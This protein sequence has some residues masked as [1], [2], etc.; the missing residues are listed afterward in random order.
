MSCMHARDAGVSCDNNSLI[1]QLLREALALFE[2]DRPT[3]RRRVLHAC[4]LVTSQTP[5]G[6]H[7]PGKLAPWQL[8]RTEKHIRE[9][10]GS[11]LRID[12]VAAAV[13]LSPNHF[14][15]AFKATVGVSYTS[16]L[17]QARIQQA[18]R[19]LLTT[20]TPIC[21]IALICG[22][23]DQSHLTRLFTRQVGLPPRAWR[24]YVLGNEP[25]AFTGDTSERSLV[26]PSADL[27]LPIVD[28]V[29]NRKTSEF[30]ARDARRVA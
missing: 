3:A 11:K 17:I 5:S 29:P 1:S 7:L 10:L 14:S 22:L 15:R 6:H 30:S 26:E 9:N 27:S 24:R 8:K 28:P 13:R 20:E 25:E 23:T 4:A 16:F 2:D 18:K 21:E 12:N 19:L